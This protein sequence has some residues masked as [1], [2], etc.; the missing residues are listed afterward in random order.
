[1]GADSLEAA[2]FRGDRGTEV[3]DTLVADV[4]SLY[5]TA[6]NSI[7]SSS[8]QEANLVYRRLLGSYLSRAHFG[9]AQQ[10]A[11]K[12]HKS[13]GD[14]RFLYWNVVGLCL[15]TYYTTDLPEKRV[16]LELASRILEKLRVA[17]KMVHAEEV[18]LYLWVL[19]K[20]DRHRDVLGLIQSP[21]IELVKIEDDRR[22]MEL[23]TRRT[24]GQWREVFDL[25][26]AVLEKSLDFT[27]WRYYESLVV[28]TVELVKQG[29]AARY[30]LKVQ[31]RC[32]LSLE[33]SLTL[34]FWLDSMGLENT[35]DAS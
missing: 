24:L 32:E 15:Q 16:S 29:D 7:S 19:E 12:Q 34:F 21:L 5:E 30:P 22:L 28:A 4:E 17:G 27:D 23:S 9:K 1:M 2:E 25:C 31:E 20:Q 26:R 13:T 8:K 18:L 3:P 11:M 35:W 10:W 33:R 6:A 14:D